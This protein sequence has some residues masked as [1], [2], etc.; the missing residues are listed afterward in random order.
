MFFGGVSADFTT[1]GADGFAV[2]EGGG[3]YGTVRLGVSLALPLGTSF[4]L[5]GCTIRFG[6]AE[7][8][9]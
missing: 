6:D 2:V 5:C 9:E 1:G 8:D 7:A 4:N 3:G